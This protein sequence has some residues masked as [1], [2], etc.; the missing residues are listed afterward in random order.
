VKKADAAKK[1]DANR[2]GLPLLLRD[3][4]A[5]HLLG[6]SRS[7]VHVWV[8]AGVL[9]AVRLPGVRAVRCSR[10]QVLQLVRSLERAA[11]ITDEISE[12]A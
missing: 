7:Q 5:A 11:G 4:E 12:V 2:L 1:A 6:V 3:T 9:S 8:R 10:T